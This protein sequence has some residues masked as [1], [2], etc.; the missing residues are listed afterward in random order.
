MIG[1]TIW[2]TGHGYIPSTSTGL[3]RQLASNHSASRAAPWREIAK[4][5]TSQRRDLRPPRGLRF[6]PQRL[7]NEAGE[8][9]RRVTV[10]TACDRVD[11]VGVERESA[12]VRR[13]LPQLRKPAE[14]MHAE[15]LGPCAHDSAFDQDQTKALTV[16]TDRREGGW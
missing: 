5:T 4:A 11:G 8:E 6:E 15:S 2:V 9:W 10:G 16:G 13:H 1:T 7:H 14:A 12:V 3:Q